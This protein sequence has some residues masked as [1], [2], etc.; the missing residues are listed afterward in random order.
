M[1]VVVVMVMVMVTIASDVSECDMCVCAII[2]SHCP[3]IRCTA[4]SPS[5]TEEHVEP[6]HGQLCSCGEDLRRR[7]LSG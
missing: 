6:G 3:G 5:A 4:T 1:V 2:A 7:Q